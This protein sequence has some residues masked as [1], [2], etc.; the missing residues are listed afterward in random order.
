MYTQIHILKIKYI[1]IYLDNV[2]LA[3]VGLFE[4][5]RVRRERKR[6]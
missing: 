4:G 6:E 5:T 1:H 3:I 2:M